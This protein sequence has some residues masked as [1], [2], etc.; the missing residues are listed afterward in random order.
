MS[1]SRRTALATGAAAITTAAITAPLA[2]K[3]GATKAALGAKAD[4]VVALVNKALPYRRW[5]D[6][7]PDDMPD[8][9]FNALC[10]PL[11]EMYDQIRLTP[12]TS[13]EGIAGKV[14]VAWIQTHPTIDGERNGP[15]EEFDI[16][17]QLAPERFIWSVLQDLE[18]LAGGLPS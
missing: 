13:V 15:P 1:I 17:G 16:I 8:E 2:L 14:R 7:T 6:S 10:R 3:A 18:R 4:P 9:E 5:L 12:A 11:W